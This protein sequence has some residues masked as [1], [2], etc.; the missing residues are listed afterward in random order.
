MA[1]KIVGTGKTKPKKDKKDKKMPANVMSEEE[2]A[3]RR[4]TKIVGTG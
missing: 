2:K 1:K 4:P 3:A